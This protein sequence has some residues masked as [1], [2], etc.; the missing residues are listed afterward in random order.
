VL[1]LNLLTPLL[2]IVPFKFTFMTKKKEKGWKK[3]E[4]KFK[5]V[6][7]ILRCQLFGKKTIINVIGIQVI[8]SLT[9]L[10][11]HNNTGKGAGKL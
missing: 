5:K 8:S 11:A 1:S 4:N 3:E 2:T 9:N 6:T 10:S 7:T